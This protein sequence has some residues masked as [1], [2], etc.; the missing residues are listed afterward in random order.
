MVG[1]KAWNWK[2]N[3]GDIWL[4]PSEESYYLL[5]RW[6][7]KKYSRFLD[8]GCGIGRHSFFFAENGFTVRAFD[9]S[10][11]AINKVKEQATLR[12]LD[13]VA[14]F[15]DMIAL[16]YQDSAFDCLLAYHV[17]SH[18]DTSGI[19]KTVNEIM[20]VLK[21]G[22]EF[23]LTLCSKKAWSFSDAGF[24]RHDE[25]TVIKTEDGPE[26]GIPHF[27]ADD[28]AVYE[29]FGEHKLIGVR[30]VQDL[31]VNCNK[32]GSWHYYILGK[33]IE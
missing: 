24:P 17:I 18:T 22:G 15:G 12:N 11:D 25:N 29:L 20:R 6:K 19:K 9:L 28:S 21:P 10:Q 3:V 16:P 32:Y 2:K 27:F 5:D 7:N 26:D 14:D 13:I 30:H 8:L 33:N 23:F 31:I 1:H 4:T